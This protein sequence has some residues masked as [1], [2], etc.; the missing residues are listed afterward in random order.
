M[1]RWLKRHFRKP[2]EKSHDYTEINFREALQKFVPIGN[3]ES[4]IFNEI[5]TITFHKAEPDHTYSR[6]LYVSIKWRRLDY[7]SKHTIP[8]DL[9]T[10]TYNCRLYGNEYLF[11]EF[12][13]VIKSGYD[14]YRK[15]IMEDLTKKMEDI[16]EDG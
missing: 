9:S 4:D 11:E 12:S 8:D 15:T 1:M 14:S 13:S 16:V 2:K 7:I 10:R 5:E 3:T 6:P